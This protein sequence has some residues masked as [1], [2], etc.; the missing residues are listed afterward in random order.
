MEEKGHLLAKKVERR[1]LRWFGNV[2]RIDERQG[3]YCR[4]ST[5]EVKVQVWLVG[6]MGRKGL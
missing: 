2:V 5:G 1:L 4:G 6:W 3:S